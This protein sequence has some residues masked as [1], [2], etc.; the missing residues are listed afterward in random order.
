MSEGGLR[1]DIPEALDSGGGQGLDAET[2][3]GDVMLVVVTVVGDITL[4]VVTGSLSGILSH[5]F[6]EI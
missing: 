2:V 3:V 4:V 5:G 6:W 1:S